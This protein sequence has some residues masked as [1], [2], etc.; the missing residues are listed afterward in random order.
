MHKHRILPGHMGGEYVPGNTITV[1]ITA[2][3]K[4]TAN[5]IMWHFANWQ[6]YGL[7]QDELAYKGLSGFYNKEDIVAQ[8]L[9]AAGKKGGKI[10]GAKTKELRVGFFAPGVQS[11]G[12]KVGGT[13]TKELG[14]G[15]HGRPLDKHLSDSRKG[16]LNQ[17]RKN[18]MSGHMKAI[19]HLS[20]ERNK[21]RACCL[22]CG[23]ETTRPA[24]GKHHRTCQTSK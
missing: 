1:E 22:K 4:T 9:S 15:I 6:L 18:A 16:G 12:G 10:G 8:Q 19:A 3:N 11:K 17:G 14:V 20:P 2:C 5:H 13:K 21:V 7:V 24:L 23:H